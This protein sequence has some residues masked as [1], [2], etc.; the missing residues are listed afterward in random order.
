[1]FTEQHHRIDLL[2]IGKITTGII[3]DRQIAHGLKALH[4]GPR[5]ML[6]KGRTFVSFLHKAVEG[7]NFVPISG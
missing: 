1:M 2:H 3:A 4:S 5:T 7:Q 6:C